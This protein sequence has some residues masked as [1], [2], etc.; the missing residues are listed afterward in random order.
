MCKTR[1]HGK[2]LDVFSTLLFSAKKKQTIEPQAFL[3]LIPSILWYGFRWEDGGGGRVQGV[4]DVV[5]T[6][7]GDRCQE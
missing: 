5:A 3:I 6:G 2:I 4:L 7:H 1:K